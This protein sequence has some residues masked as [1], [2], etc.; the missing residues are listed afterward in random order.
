MSP[1][2]ACIVPPPGTNRPVLPY[3][4]SCVISACQLRS[5][6]K[7]SSAV[8][9]VAQSSNLRRLSGPSCAGRGWSVGREITKDSRHNPR[10]C[11]VGLILHSIDE[12]GHS[13]SAAPLHV[14][15]CGARS[16][17]PAQPGQGARA[18]RWWVASLAGLP[19]RGSM[20]LPSEIYMLASSASLGGQLTHGFRS[21]DP[22]VDW[23]IHPRLG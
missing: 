15:C 17:Q 16:A 14:C 18:H 22:A 21:G 4:V 1:R 12:R 20:C 6:S 9:G 5:I 7:P 19:S 11:A 3:G 13:S 8:P 10:S 2:A 23:P